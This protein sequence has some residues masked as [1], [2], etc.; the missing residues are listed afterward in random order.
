MDVDEAVVAK[1]SGGGSAGVAALVGVAAVP[2]P[3][4]QLQHLGVAPAAAQVVLPA[5]AVVRVVELVSAASA[6]LVAHVA[7]PM[8][9]QALPTVVLPG[10]VPGLVPVA[11]V[12]EAVG[13]AVGATA[14]ATVAGA[15][16]VVVM[17][18]HVDV[19]AGVGGQGLAIGDG[20]TVVAGPRG[21]AL[22]NSSN[23][24]LRLPRG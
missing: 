20:A 22:R 14:V 13:G 4:L 12:G 7:T 24:R 1:V 5:P 17:V 19:D 6:S 10:R 21:A 11:A 15:M 23:A 16:E 18:V 8:G 9:A 2:V 3:P